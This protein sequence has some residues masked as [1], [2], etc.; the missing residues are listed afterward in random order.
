MAEKPLD[1]WM[2]EGSPGAP[3]RLAISDQDGVCIVTIHEDEMITQ[4]A[5]ESLTHHAMNRV[6]RMAVPRL[7][8]DIQKV[9]AVSSRMLGELIAIQGDLRGKS[10]GL[11]L[12]RM[13]PAVLE[14]FVVTKLDR[15]IPI[16][17]SVAEA[18]ESLDRS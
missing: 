18:V 2:E 13:S 4:S 12:A 16:F 1:D 7:A 9:E 8:I 14:V 15:R 3:A 10:G 6:L 11:A 17:D 5:I